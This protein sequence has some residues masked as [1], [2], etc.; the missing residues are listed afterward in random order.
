MIITGTFYLSLMYSRNLYL[1]PV[2][3]MSGPAVNA[4]FR[5]IFDDK[6]KLSSR[7]PVWVSTGKGKEFLNKD[8]QDMLRD[9]GIQFQ[10]CRNPDVKCAVVERAKRTIRDR[11]YKYLT[12]KNTFRYIDVLPK[13]VRAYNDTVHSTT[14]M[15]PSRVTDSDVLAIWKRMNRRRSCIRVAKLKFS[16]GQP[17]RI[18]KE[19]MK[20]A[21]GGEQT[22]ST[23]IFRI[24]KVI[25]RR[26]RPVY[27]LE[28]LNK[29]PI[30]GQFHA[31]GL[32]PVRIMEETAYKID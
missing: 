10:V 25:E 29:T 12:Y 8:F 18:S 9:E 30:E 21:N 22:F 6:P 5:S 11:V 26:P 20:F 32:T 15:A 4:S 16:V 19:K 17:V 13:F 28:D 7:R 27:E 14:G 24:T 2:K 3:T 31:E 23:E 1:I